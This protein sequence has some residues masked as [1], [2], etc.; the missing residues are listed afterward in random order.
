MKKKPS[1]KVL[2]RVEVMLSE[3]PPVLDFLSFCAWDTTVAFK[4]VTTEQ[5]E[6]LVDVLVDEDPH[7][8]LNVWRSSGNR[9]R[10]V[11]AGS[12]LDFQ[13]DLQGKPRVQ[14]AS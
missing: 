9:W 6:E 3:Q 14:K 2:H 4:E 1:P 5:L 10:I 8:Y 12:P 11:G 13:A 7:A